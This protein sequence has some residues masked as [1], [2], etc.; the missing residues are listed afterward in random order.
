MRTASAQFRTRLCLSVRSVGYDASH[1]QPKPLQCHGNLP[2]VFLLR[3]STLERDNSCMGR[4]FSAGIPRYVRQKNLL[5][6][7]VGCTRKTGKEALLCEPYP[8]CPVLRLPLLRSE[9]QRLFSRTA[10]SKRARINSPKQVQRGRRKAL[11]P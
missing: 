1:K 8:P 2:C 4:P 3:G 7:K 10:Y 5:V 6:P 9:I 11:S